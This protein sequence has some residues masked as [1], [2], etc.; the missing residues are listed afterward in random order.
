MERGVFAMKTNDICFVR[1]CIADGYGVEDIEVMS[2]LTLDEIR[3]E[4]SEMREAG[5]LKAM[6]GGTEEK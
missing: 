1:E 3:A 4:V 5:T 6:F 2:M